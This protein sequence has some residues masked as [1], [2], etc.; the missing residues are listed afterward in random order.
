MGMDLTLML[1]EK[2]NHLWKTKMEARLVRNYELLNQFDPSH[3][4]FRDLPEACK[5]ESV[6]PLPEGETFED[7]IN[8]GERVND[9]Y[10]GRALMMDPS[11]L[12]KIETTYVGT[13]EALARLTANA[14]PGDKV[15]LF[16]H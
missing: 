1:V 13:I 12:S 15:I 14:A 10:G 5:L 7:R 6:A 11:E 3:T 16:W 2:Q 9:P 8:G 4:I